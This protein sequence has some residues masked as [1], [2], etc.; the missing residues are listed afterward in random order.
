[1]A[2]IYQIKFSSLLIILLLLASYGSPI[3]AQEEPIGESEQL[4]TADGTP[5][6][7]KSVF[8]GGGS[9]G[10]DVNQIEEIREFLETEM[11]EN[12]EIHIH[13]H[14]DNIGSKRYNLY[15]STK[16]SET[17]FDIITELVSPAN[18]V[19][20]KDHGLSNPEFNNRTMEGR[21]KNRRV[22]I[23]LWP[24]PV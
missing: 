15:L 4:Y 18:Q 14:T 16:R 11:I 22:D 1:M 19:F 12:Y 7:I 13:S 9:Y 23:V 6:K 20:I 3:L 17:V 2:T 8:F 21:A 24:L 10:V 5:Y